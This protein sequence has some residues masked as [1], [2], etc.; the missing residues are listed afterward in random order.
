[1]IGF[2]HMLGFICLLI[3]FLITYVST[4][5]WIRVARR[6]GL[7][8]KDM[9]KPDDKQVPEAG[10][11]AVIIGIGISLICYV[12]FKI[13]LISTKTHLIQTFALLTTVFFAFFIGFV[14]DILGWKKGLKQWRKVLFT[15]PIALPIMAI[16][17]GHS[18]VNIPFTMELGII[19]PLLVVPVGIIGAANGFNFIAGFNGLEAGQGVLIFGILGTIS[20][21]IGEL[22]I[23]LVCF[24]VVFSLFAF[25]VFNRYPS[26]VFPGDSLTYPLG[27]LIAVVC[28]LA[29][30][31]S[32]GIVLFIPYFI[33]FL[34]K[35]R[36]EFN[37]ESFGE[38]TSDGSIKPRYDK[39]YSINHICLKLGMDESTSTICIW[40]F[41]FL[42]CC[43]AVTMA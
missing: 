6:E 31:E 18:I 34:L 14:D 19:Y 40:A 20:Y 7:F 37:A 24:S 25:L 13:F 22:W 12:F 32:I 8:G 27:A 28:I 21:M 4:R 3:S 41:Q 15:L 10:G 23:S 33:E 26:E 38:S 42:I 9:N 11:V 35:A 30:M 36:S 29:N 17:A 39:V 43:L 2:Q 16:N 5:F 1:M